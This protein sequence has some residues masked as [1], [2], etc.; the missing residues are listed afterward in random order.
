MFKRPI[1][2]GLDI[3]SK[4]IKLVKA[5]AKGNAII[6]QVLITMD[7]PPGTVDAGIIIDPELLGQEL[8]VLVTQHGFNGANVISAVSGQQV[9]TR[10]LILPEMKANELR[11]AVVNQ[12]ISFL[13][14]P[15][16]EAAMDVFKLRTFTDEEGKKVEV[17]YVAA[18]KIQVDSL[19][20]VCLAAGLK[21]AAVE[22]E[23]LALYRV[24]LS[25]DKENEVNAI[26]NIGASRSYMAVFEGPVLT[27]VRN[28]SFGCSVF[29][30]GVGGYGQSNPNTQLEDIDLNE[31]SS[32]SYLIGDMITEVS[33]TIEY[34][35]LQNMGQKIERIIICGGGS[36]LKGLD[37][38]LG[39]ALGCN[40][41]MANLSSRVIIP[42]SF[43]VQQKLALVHECPVALGL[44]ARGVL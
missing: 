5:R 14:I 6:P 28:M 13:P 27:A 25:H 4:K 22:I 10:K 8:S 16:E 21:L 31:D 32:Y 9:Y 33:R 19:L 15:P 29:Y 40:V 38:V 43:D 39:G 24:L 30:L 26:L 17:F 35:S 18:R 41:E 11:Q 2:L 44:A 1:L 23:P 3:G 37:V 36:R 42:S 20:T 12:S 34:Y 7:T